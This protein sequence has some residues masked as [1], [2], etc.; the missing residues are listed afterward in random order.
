MNIENENFF[1]FFG[2]NDEELRSLYAI[3]G[4]ILQTAEIHVPIPKAPVPENGLN[5]MGTEVITF[6]KRNEDWIDIILIVAIIV[7]VGLI[8]WR[9]YIWYNKEPEDERTILENPETEE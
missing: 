8:V 4:E 5:A 3:S 1:D 2:L 9:V 6:D 7:L